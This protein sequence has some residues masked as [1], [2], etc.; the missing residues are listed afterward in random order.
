MESYYIVLYN[1][2]LSGSIM[3]VWIKYRELSSCPVCEVRC[4]M[5]KS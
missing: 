1:R 5:L 4:R 3:H 2:E